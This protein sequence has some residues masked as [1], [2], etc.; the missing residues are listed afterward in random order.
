MHNIFRHVHNTSDIEQFIVIPS[1]SH[2]GSTR[3]ISAVTGHQ[4]SLIKK[5]GEKVL[6]RVL[7]LKKKVDEIA[8]VYFLFSF[9]V[10]YVVVVHI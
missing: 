3:I 1:K 10:I 2:G 6:N 5:N 9:I 7:E 4:A 8:V